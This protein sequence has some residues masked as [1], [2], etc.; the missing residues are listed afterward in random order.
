MSRQFT[1]VTGHEDLDWPKLAAIEG[2]LV[3]LMGATRV[4]R[5]AKELVRAGR[6]A[7][8]PVAVIE[9][10]TLPGQ[11]TTTGT[12][13]TIGDR[14]TAVGVRAPAVVVVGDVATMHDLLGNAAAAS[15]GADMS[16]PALLAVAHGS[17][18][19]R[20]EQVL[21]ALVARVRSERPGLVAVLAYLGFSDPSVPTAL[22]ALARQGVREV[23]VVPLLLTAA[24]HAK[25]DLPGLLSQAAL[26][27][28]QLAIRQAEVLG[29][30]PLLFELVRRRLA[31][32]GAEPGMS[33]V[34]AAVGTSDPGA[35]AELAD[36]AATLG[37]TIGFASGSPAI[38]DVVAGQ[39]AR[40]A[41]Q[42]ALATYVLAPGEFSDRLQ[43][44]GADVVTEV[45]GAAPEVV[46]VVLFR[47]DARVQVA[48]R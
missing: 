26:D 10:G 3:L 36:V 17:A 7:N 4:E 1:V 2:T 41:R 44:A 45:L 46:D 24:Y 28:P 27:H 13:D 37:A 30:H 18:D 8:T 34:L 14:A 25:V 12:L 35:N 16:E 47:Y 20:A 31:E 39:R 15:G 38:A 23:V 32:A 19:P 6:D 5:I 40:G 43:D 11:R 9:S 33:V 42:V 29:P 22:E 21:D 48:W